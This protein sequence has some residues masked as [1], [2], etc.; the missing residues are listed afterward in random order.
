MH[1][2][3]VEDLSHL[4]MQCSANGLDW[5]ELVLDVSNIVHRLLSFSSLISRS[6]ANYV[7]ITLD[8]QYPVHLVHPVPFDE[9]EMEYQTKTD[10]ELAAVD[11]LVSP[12]LVR[13]GDASGANYGKQVCICKSG[14]AY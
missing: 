7:A 10:P 14:V 9:A 4:L 13:Y 5:G 1:N 12:G 6:V 11:L 8:G 3:I 2:A